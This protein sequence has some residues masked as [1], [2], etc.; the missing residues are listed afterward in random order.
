MALPRVVDTLLQIPGIDI[1]ITNDRDEDALMLAIG[2]LHYLWQ[3]NV[4]TLKIIHMLLCNENACVPDEAI[5]AVGLVLK[6]YADAVYKDASLEPLCTSL[7]E[8]LLQ[9][10]SIVAKNTKTAESCLLEIIKLPAAL[11]PVLIDITE[12]ASTIG[13]LL[14]VDG[15]SIDEPSVSVEEKKFEG[16]KKAKA[17]MGH[18]FGYM[19]RYQEVDDEE[20]L[21]KYWAVTDKGEDKVS[22]AMIATRHGYQ[23]TNGKE[24]RLKGK[25]R[26]GSSIFHILIEDIAD[27]SSLEDQNISDNIM[28][29]LLKSIEAAAALKDVDMSMKNAEGLT[30][31]D[32]CV[33]LYMEDSLPLIVFLQMMSLLNQLDTCSVDQV[34]SSLKILIWNIEVK[35]FGEGIEKGHGAV[36]ESSKALY[37]KVIRSLCQQETFNINST[38]D[39]GATLGHQ[40]AMAGNE[41]AMDVIMDLPAFDPNV[42]D[43]K[44]NTA[45]FYILEMFAVEHVGIVVEKASWDLAATN[46]LGETVLE[47]SDN[48]EDKSRGKR[49]QG[50]LKVMMQG[51]GH[52]KGSYWSFYY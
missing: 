49:I 6:K 30:S 31:G 4:S 1:N 3:D 22:I 24:V 43:K 2:S 15:V 36:G 52:D 48:M 27:Y 7:L 32:L 17:R 42:K 21:P 23:I 9:C 40:A 10:F 38:D 33:K 8:S 18:Y 26:K 12:Y 25:L 41:A 14:S 39:E 34:F 28:R 44:G 50:L 37:P 45:L 20:I 46:A 47:Y 13:Q 5:P 35:M 16:F 29:N 11:S 19:V 51:K